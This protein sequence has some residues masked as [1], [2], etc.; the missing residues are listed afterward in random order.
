L[1]PLPQT[2]DYRAGDIFSRGV[3]AVA[4]VALPYRIAWQV[5]APAP[6]VRGY[7][8][9]LALIGLAA[10]ILGV[11]NR[12]TSNSLF[13]LPPAVDLLPP[14]S[15][16]T[17]QLAFAA[18]QQDPLYAAC[19]GTESLGQYQL[20]YWWE[21]LRR[22]SVL[23]L[24]ATGA[25]GVVG[26]LLSPRFRFVLPR[27][28]TLCALVGAYWLT[29]SLVA[30]IVS[31]VDVVSQFDTGQYD[32][33]LNVTF[34]SAALALVLVSAVAPP[35]PLP[36]RRANDWKKSIWIGLIL[37]DIVF[38]ALCAA[39]DAALFWPTWP[40]YH[41]AASPPL[42][43]LLS[44]SPLWLNLTVNPYMLQFVHRLLSS[45]L[46]LSALIMAIAGRRD[47]QR[48]KTSAIIFA[49][50]TL[51]MAA[52]ILT[53]ALGVPP[54]LSMAHQIGGAVVLAGTFIAFGGGSD[55]AVA[56]GAAA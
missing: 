2:L 31:Q 36:R 11:E 7:F 4:D 21:W 45:G 53:L 48:L 25:I 27:L 40:G 56:T 17:W 20:L 49:L 22:V 19:L 3:M 28:A 54:M 10:F 1:L 14:W 23:A 35:I 37:L 42:A 13:Y 29:R 50:L 38:G 24:A 8:V 47:P 43:Q 5:F 26:A 30:F 33:A 9:L 51:E 55:A 44:Y 16:Q 18:H 15:M 41:G 46:W 52:G 39:R 6:W 32:T 12:F 34:A